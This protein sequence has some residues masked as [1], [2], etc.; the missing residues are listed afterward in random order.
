MKRSGTITLPLT[1]AAVWKHEV[2]GQISD[3][4]WE[5]SAPHNHWQF[6][7]ALETNVGDTPSVTDNKEFAC[8]R[9]TYDVV[10]L[11]NIDDH[12]LMPRMLAYG[13][14]ALA[15]GSIDWAHKY[16]FAAELLM[17]FS[18]EQRKQG[19]ASMRADESNSEYVKEAL[20]LIDDEF[21]DKF[22]A[23]RYTERDL[24]RDLQ[25]IK[26]LLRSVPKHW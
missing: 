7:C 1:A 10:R 4:N 24:R 8:R 13:K 19:I 3:G 9:N 21:I 12:M 5:N 16:G 17:E 14:L 15:T 2:C 20:K 11:M 23:T 25:V 6:W 22:N 18:P 26:K